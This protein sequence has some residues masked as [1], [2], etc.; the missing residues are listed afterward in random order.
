ML[1][2]L[3]FFFEKTPSKKT[4]CFMFF[5]LFWLLSCSFICFHVVLLK[6]LLF[7]FISSCCSSSF[8][9]FSLFFVSSC[10]LVSFI[11]PSLSNFILLISFLSLCFFMSNSVQKMYFFELLQNS[12][13]L[14]SL[15]HQNLS[16]LCFLFCWAFLRLIYFSM[17]CFSVSWKMVSHFVWL[18]F[19]RFFL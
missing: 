10:F 5:G 2:T 11:F 3:R 17:F 13:F 19:F 12:L 4:A 6:W 14:S 8:H 16:F 9:L 18:S 1:W 7:L 15:F